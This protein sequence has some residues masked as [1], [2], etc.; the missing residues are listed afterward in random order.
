MNNKNQIYLWTVVGSILILGVLGFVLWKFKDKF[1]GSIN[2]KKSTSLSKQEEQ[3]PTETETLPKSQGSGAQ[4]PPSDQS[5][6]AQGG[7]RS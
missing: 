4:G 3:A 5:G 7:A 1:K 2:T 6:G